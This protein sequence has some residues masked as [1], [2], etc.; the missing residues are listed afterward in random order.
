M[1]H[2][3]TN[4]LFLVA[5]I[6]SRTGG[7]EQQALQLA[8]ALQRRN[9]RI[10]FVTAAYWD[11]MSGDRLPLE[12][13]V[14]G[15]TVYRI[16]IFR[17]WRR[18]NALLYVVGALF[19]L[20]RH[21]TRYSV[22]HAHGLYSSG[23][24]A[25]VGK[26]LMPS[27]KVVIK[28]GA[29]GSWLGDVAHLRRLPASRVLRAVV[30]R[31][32]DVLVGVSPQVCREL[33][34]AGLGRVEAL[35]NGV[36]TGRFAPLAPAEAARLK[37]GL[38]GPD[39]GRPV[40]LFVGRLGAEKNVS[41]LLQSLEF[42]RT[43]V[44][45]VIAGEGEL[46]PALETQA[47]AAPERHH[48]R[49]LGTVEH[50]EQVYQIADAFVLPSLTEGSPN[51]LLEAMST[52]VPSIGSDIPGIRAVITDELTGCIFKQPHDLAAQLERVLTDR[53]LAGRLSLAARQHVRERFS[54]DAVADQYRQI[55][56]SLA[57]SAVAG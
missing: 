57:S 5:R 38:L 12:G 27:K 29:G 33:H 56:S 34:E 53:D 7:M 31:C 47:A 43:P 16:P 9:C 42:V 46:R 1:K 30:R 22:I 51:V 41:V 39:T 45:L 19:L 37:V 52:G 8:S 44:T 17:T 14:G 11:W 2:S 3:T 23:L 20:V 15:F 4:V 6:D 32:A 54:L 24:I 49:F 10:F 55:Y 21:R 40:V 50:I 25:C 28:A 35:A 13:T 36:D 48:V 18:L 26:L